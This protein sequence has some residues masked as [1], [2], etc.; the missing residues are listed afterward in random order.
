MLLYFLRKDEVNEK[1]ED[2]L[3][4]TSPT[5]KR[6]YSLIKNEWNIED[7]VTRIAQR[8]SSSLP[9]NESGSAFGGMLRTL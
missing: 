3:I 5:K 1:T 4:I 8:G 6:G 7:A 2:E 9:E